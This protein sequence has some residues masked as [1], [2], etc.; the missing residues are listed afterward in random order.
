MGLV[1]AMRLVVQ[2]IFTTEHLALI[3]SAKQLMPK[4][5]VN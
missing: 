4:V 2:K 1:G 5:T 3:R